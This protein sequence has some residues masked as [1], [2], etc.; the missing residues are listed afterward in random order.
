MGEKKGDAR[1][2]GKES[3]L[4][5]GGKNV[6]QGTT[7]EQK[8]GVGTTVSARGKRIGVGAPKRTIG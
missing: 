4:S 5:P 6:Q 1:N 3:C 2:K 7:I 8:W